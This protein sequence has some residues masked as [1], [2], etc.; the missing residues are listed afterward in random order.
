MDL[1]AV[2]TEIKS[3]WEA[4]KAAQDG[5]AAEIKARGEALGET[6]ALVEKLNERLSG[7]EAKAT[8]PAAPEA[9]VEAKAGELT[10]SGKAFVKALRTKVLG[11][12]LA[13]E[14]KALV[15]DSTGQLIVPFDMESE[16][17]RE[18]GK[19]TVVRGLSMVRSTNRD[20]VRR[21]SMNE[22]SVGWGKLE[23]AAGGALPESTL[24]PDEAYQYVEDQIGLAKLGVDEL[25]DTDLN[26]YGYL[27][28]SYGQAFSEHEDTGFLTGT[29]HAA[30]QPEGIL[31]GAT[32]TRI[33]TAAA[34]AVSTNDVLDLVYAVPAQ[35]RRGSAFI[36]NSATVKALRKL[37]NAVDGT[38]LWQ[39]SLQAGEP[40]TLFSYPIAEQDD[41]PAI[42]GDGTAKDV[43]VFG[44]FGRGYRVL[45]RRVMSV[46]RLNELYATGGMVGFLVTRRVGG[47]VIRPKALRILKTKAA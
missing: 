1:K 29:G 13:Q 28:D 7:L 47:A 37:K 34:N 4:L 16:I 3:T 15:E 46:Q 22:V 23:T 24:V 14:E 30:V 5:M 43:M 11:A 19:L 26:V 10:A 25:E 36:A 39:P 6:K 9:K 33:N 12:N 42:P 38:Y 2:L 45:D 21:I 40:A 32:V 35:Y 18:L 27:V 31:N 8:R 44:N 17:Y 20:R 41:I